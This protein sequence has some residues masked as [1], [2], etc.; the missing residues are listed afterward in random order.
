MGSLRCDLPEVLRRGRREAEELEI[1]R[2]LLEQHVD[3]R[4]HPAAAR[5]RRGRTGSCRRS[6]RRRRRKPRAQSA[7]RRSASGHLCHAQRRGIDDDVAGQPDRSLGRQHDVR[8]GRGETLGQRACALARGSH[9]A[10]DA[11]PAAAS[12]AA[13]ADPTPPA[14]ATSARA[15]SSRQ[16][17]ARNARTKP[18]P[19]N[20]SPCRRPSAGT[21]HRVA[22]AGEPHGWRRLVEQRHRGH[23]VRHRDERAADVG[24]PEHGGEARWK[25]LGAASHRYHHRIDAGLLEVGVV[26]QRR[27]ERMRREADVGDERRGAADRHA[28]PPAQSAGARIPRRARPARPPACRDRPDGSDTSRA[29]ST[30]RRRRSRSPRR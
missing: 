27:H 17:L 14:P 28:E 5:L 13:M 16:P 30:P 23:F 12:D 22:R 25:M 18:S 20:R 24:Q 6:S 8:V 9:S 15:P 21:P 3:A 2:N 26:D 7:R 29:C 4:L 19:S 11:R 10:I 1:E